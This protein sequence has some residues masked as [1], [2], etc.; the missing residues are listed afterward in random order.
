MGHNSI[1]YAT[2]QIWLDW[3]DQRFAKGRHQGRRRS[4]CK[5]SA[6]EIGTHAPRPL[7]EY[8]QG[9]TYVLEHSSEDYMLA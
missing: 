8:Q 2:Q 3:L 6:R 4:D 1:L 9:L 7:G 5:C